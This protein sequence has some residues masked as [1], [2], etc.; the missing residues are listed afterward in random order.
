MLKL[1][2][3]ALLASNKGNLYDELQN[4]HPVH[5][6]SVD[7]FAFGNTL[8]AEIQFNKWLYSFL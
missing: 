3:A 4:K 8:N 1:R 2:K 5:G 7:I 6:R